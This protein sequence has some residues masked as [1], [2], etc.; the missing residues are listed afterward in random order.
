MGIS[1]KT[2]EVFSKTS[3]GGLMCTL[4]LTIFWTL[5]FH[6]IVPKHILTVKIWQLVQYTMAGDFTAIYRTFIVYTE[7]EICGIM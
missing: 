2:I 1:L 7:S 5:K 6:N 3:A 4:N